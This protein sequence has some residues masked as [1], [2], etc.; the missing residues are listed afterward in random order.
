MFHPGIR[1]RLLLFFIFPLFLQTSCST[2]KVLGLT[3]Q[4]AA[5]MMQKG[6]IDFIRQSS[7]DF[8]QAGFSRTVSRLKELEAV[9]PGAPFYAALLADDD[10]D[11]QILLYCAA[12]ESPSFPA[13]REAVSKMLSI[14]FDEPETARINTEDILGFLDSDNLKGKNEFLPILRAACLYRMGRY[15]EI[16]KPLTEYLAGSDAG[17]ELPVKWGKAIGLFATWNEGGNAE[18]LKN[19]ITAILFKNPVDE[20]TR[21]AYS[22]ALSAGHLLSPMETAAITARRSPGNY[23]V[24]IN[25]LRPA[26]SGDVLFFFRHPDLIADLG[27]AY[28]YTPGARDEGA[29]LFRTWDKML[30][31]EGPFSPAKFMV[32]FYTGRIERARERYVE[33]S[34]Y[35]FRALGYAPDELQADSCI[36]YM[37][38]NAVSRDPSTAVSLVLGTMPQWND[39]SYFSD[40]LDR[41]SFYLTG[42]RQWAN[43]MEIYSRLEARGN[44]ASLAQYAWILGRAA[45]EGY[46]TPERNTESFFRIAFEESNASF[47]YRVMAATVLGETLVPEIEGRTAAQQRAVISPEAEFILGFFEYSASSFVTPYIR[48]REAELSIPELRK[49]AEAL[50]ALNRWKESIDLVSRYMKRENY[51]LNREDLYLYYPQPYREL[52]E[53]YAGEMGLGAEILYGLIHT[54]SLFMSDVSSW[55]GAIGLVQ[56]MPATAEEMAGRI[57]RQGGPDYR[58]P[59]TNLRDPE[60]N[61]HIGSYYLRYLTQQMQSPMLALLAYNG[62]MG[63]V[64]RWLAA[65]R[66]RGV[67]P[68]DLFLETVEYTETREYGRRVLAAAAAYGY[69][70]YG[71]SMEEV[72]ADIYPADRHP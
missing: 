52:I 37:L 21:W 22:E 18:S 55:V 56:L 65:D 28:Q 68:L 54:E 43:I 30:E 13:R 7:S 15:G 51:K 6:D 10:R 47:Y 23:S 41:L 46:I 5:E 26:I 64:R 17:E 42:R 70:Y 16:V 4:E 24:I 71:M 34:E 20:V 19:E 53:K 12:L 11:L 59:E 31:A 36:W 39:M 49:T 33:S 45:Q 2:A 27:R 61:I 3:R 1:N 35:F 66:R 25:N 38:M 44:S 29:E 58:G 69:L 9:H 40:V 14:I 32:L 57:V 50:G 63:R 62:G 67:L 72:A 48:A 60:V 8:N